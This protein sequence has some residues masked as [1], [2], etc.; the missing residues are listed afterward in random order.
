MTRHDLP[1]YAR[2]EKLNRASVLSKGR[3]GT[4][5]PASF[6]FLV[7]KLT[8]KKLESAEITG[9]ML[10]QRWEISESKNWSVTGS[11]RPM[12]N[13]PSGVFSRTWHGF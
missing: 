12:A 6:D 9:M 11:E 8:W 7:R 2:Q 1:H 10:I 5:L 13:V 3:Q 4:T